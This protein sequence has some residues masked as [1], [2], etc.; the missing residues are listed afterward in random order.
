MTFH[1]AGHSG[2]EKHPRG[3]RA[4]VRRLVADT[5][6]STVAPVTL[7]SMPTLRPWP[8]TTV[9]LLRDAIHN[10]DPDG[11]RG[12]NHMRAYANQALAMSTRNA[13]NAVSEARLS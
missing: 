11:R 9:T 10:I 2:R 6:P 8:A 3:S 13:P 7:R 4:G 12:R 1:S 5:D